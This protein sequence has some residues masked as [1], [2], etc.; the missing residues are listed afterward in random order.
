MGVTQD[1]YSER[2]RPTPE[3]HIPLDPAAARDEKP[4]VAL[5]GETG[6]QPYISQTAADATCRKCAWR[7]E[8]LQYHWDSPEEHDDED[9]FT[10]RV[11]ESLNQALRRGMH[12]PW[13]SH[14][15]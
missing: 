4:F 9:K 7:W 5:C 15:H 3:R 2:M 10:K 14:R 8:Y 12:M 1:T 13:D 6:E 11:L